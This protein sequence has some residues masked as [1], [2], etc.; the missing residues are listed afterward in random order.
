MKYER[1]F[2]NDISDKGLMSKYTNNS[3]I[4]TKQNKQTKNH[5]DFKTRQR[6]SIDIFPKRTYRWPTGT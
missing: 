5:P 1:I 4:K 2:A 6:I 3:Y